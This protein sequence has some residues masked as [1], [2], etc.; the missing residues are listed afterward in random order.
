M[1]YRLWQ[2]I[3]PCAEGQE[4]LRVPSF[5][6]KDFTTSACGCAFLPD[7]GVKMKGAGGRSEARN[8][9]MAVAVERGYQF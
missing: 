7:F 3:K 2:C 5:I 1:V 9:E 4:Q 8:N 6:H